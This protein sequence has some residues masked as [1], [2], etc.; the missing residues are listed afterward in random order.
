MPPGT[1]AC[2]LRSTDQG[3]RDE[4]SIVRVADACRGGGG[5]TDARLAGGEYEDG[6][7]LWNV[8]LM[9]SVAL[10]A[11]G[12]LKINHDVVVPRGPRAEFSRVAGAAHAQLRIANSVSRDREH[13]RHLEVDRRDTEQRPRRMA[14]RAL[15]ACRRLE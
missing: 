13:P 11:T 12:L 2:D 10:K 6:E 1:G 8:R 9:L 5:G 15:F 14:R 4:R 7:P 3:G